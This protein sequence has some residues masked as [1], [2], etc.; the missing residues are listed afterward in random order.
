MASSRKTVLV[1]DGEERAALA[2]VR[3]LGRAGY[4]CVVASRQGRSISGAS[5]F[6][7]CEFVAPPP[8]T[9]PDQFTDA[10]MAIAESRAVDLVIPISEASL[11]AILQVRDQLCAPVPFP[12]A[13]IV[14]AICDKKRVLEVASK[15]GIRVPQQQVLYCRNE[16]HQLLLQPPVVLKPTRSVYTA[17]DGTRGKVGV[18]WVHDINELEERVLKYPAEAFPLLVQEAI[19]GPGIGVFVLRDQGETI[20][21]FAHRRIREMPP[22]GGVSVLRQSEPMD[23]ALYERTINLL[24]AF[25]WSGV[26]MVEY[27][28]DERSGEPV[29]MEIN[30]R[31]WGSLQ[32]AVDAGVDF[33]RLLA[34]IN[35]GG[36]PPR[37]RS[38]RFVRSR[39]FWG[40]V[41]HAIARWRDR[42]STWRDRVNAVA[43][44][45]RACSPAYRSEVL[46]WNDP[47]PFVRESAQWLSH[48][49][50][51]I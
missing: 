8:D 7:T 38:Y 29:L 13:D 1:T 36:K 16:L 10:V 50:R 27:K 40:D 32:L 12:S 26:A 49:I 18:T 43:A 11:L 4:Q 48:A 37:T 25:G 28:V 45:V 34:E 2:V 39:W 30:G 21:R 33:P 15:L 51:H 44:M 20:A 6:T 24:D 31:F 47:M 9:A 17:P 23:E 14:R 41:D 5:R 19:C 3:S 46:H 42:G 22:S 35:L